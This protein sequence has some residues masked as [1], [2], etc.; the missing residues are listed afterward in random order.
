MTFLQFYFICCH[1]TVKVC[2]R[3]FYVIYIHITH[4]K[5]PGANQ[6]SAF[7]FHFTGEHLVVIEMIALHEF[8]LCDGEF[9]LSLIS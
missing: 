3:Q 9:L 8:H 5:P 7:L 6:M 1:M 2:S 4:P